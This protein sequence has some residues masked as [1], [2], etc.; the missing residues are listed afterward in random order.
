MVCLDLFFRTTR[1]GKECD[2][3]KMESR[4]RHFLYSCTQLN[5]E[6]GVRIWAR[7]RSSST[8]AEG[9]QACSDGRVT[10]RA[11]KAKEAAMETRRHFIKTVGAVG[12]G[13]AL[14]WRFGTYSIQAAAN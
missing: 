1:Q 10:S 13:M 4:R 9:E 3:Q 2:Y 11:N 14:P 8:D 6:V 7:L 12:A 5:H